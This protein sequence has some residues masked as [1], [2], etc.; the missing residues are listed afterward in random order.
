MRCRAA[1]RTRA[2][3]QDPQFDAYGGFPAYSG[4]L[5]RGTS[6]TPPRFS[7]SYKD[8]VW[9]LDAGALHGLPTEP[10]KHV[11]LVLYPD[12]VSS[13]AGR[14]STAVVGA[15]QSEVQLDFDAD[16]TVR[17]TAELTSLPVPPTPIYFDGDDQI[18]KAVAAALARNRT[19]TA[20][21]TDIAEGARY[22]L[23]LERGA[24]H[25]RQR[26]TD[27]LH[28]GCDTRPGA[29][30]RERRPAAARHPA[31]GPMGQVLGAAEPGHPDERL[32][33]RL[34]LRRAVGE[35]TGA[36]ISGGRHRPRFREV[37]RRVAEDCRPVQG[38]QSYASSRCMSSSPI[39][40]RPT[41]SG[42][43][44]TSPIPPGGEWVTLPV[45]GDPKAAFW[46]DEPANHATE[47]FKLFVSTEKVDDFLLEQDD[48]S[49]GATV[50]STRGFGS[51]KSTKKYRNEWF[52]R[53]LVVTVVRRLNHVSVTNASL[54]QGKIVVKAHPLGQGRAQSQRRQERR[55]QRR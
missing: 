17:Y 43:S 21:I 25:F 53:N 18:R 30:G 9:T 23:T 55:S 48:L 5:G 33:G 46:V 49:M 36:R 41:G 26:E 27:T 29:S 44:P 38:A 28:P 50:S 8:N 16:T 10:E 35:R 19:V 34:R 37:R 12:G 51:A 15:Q 32:A 11:E 1:V 13:A 31:R 45:D 14:G 42:S 54:A 22:A 40:R 52:T 3:H 2:E 7:V 47:R 6:R 4:F 39:S 24:L 20:A